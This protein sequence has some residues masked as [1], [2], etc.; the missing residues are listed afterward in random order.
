MEMHQKISG[1]V[2]QF[3]AT[4]SLR[5]IGRMMSAETD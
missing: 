3:L 4:F 1:G 2:L 5:L